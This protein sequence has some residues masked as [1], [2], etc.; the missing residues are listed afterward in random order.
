MGRRPVTRQAA[1]LDSARRQEFATYWYVLL[2]AGKV[3]PA[4][5]RRWERWASA[6]ENLEA[7]EQAKVAADPATICRLIRENGL[8][9]EHVPTRWLNE[10]S[11]WEALLERIRISGVSHELSE[12]PLTGER[13]LFVAMAPGVVIELVTE[14]QPLTP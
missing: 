3:S 11:V 1:R 4:G 5:R 10:P 12:V 7:F 13:Q 9:R 8:V 14:Q 2:R 6:P